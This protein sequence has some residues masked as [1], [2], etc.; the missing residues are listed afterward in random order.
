MLIRATILESC[1]MGVTLA[2]VTGYQSNLKL[3]KDI[4]MNGTGT[5]VSVGNTKRRILI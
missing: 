1:H 5:E 2:N 4:D 3:Y